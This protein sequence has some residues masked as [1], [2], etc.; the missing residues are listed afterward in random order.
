MHPFYIHI[1]H[2]HDPSQ[3]A[4]RPAKSVKKRHAP[5]RLNLGLP[6]QGFPP[7]LFDAKTDKAIEEFKRAKDQRLAPR[8]SLRERFGFALIRAGQRLARVHVAG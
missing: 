4:Y 3:S 2:K 6:S 5:E 1:D 8:P 7:L